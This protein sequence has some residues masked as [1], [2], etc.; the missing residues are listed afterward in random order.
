MKA[1]IQ[2]LSKSL[3]SGNLVEPCGD[4]SVVCL[5]GRNALKTMINDGHRF[6]GFRRPNYPHFRV[7]QGDFRHSICVFSTVPNEQRL[8]SI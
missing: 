5:D 4:R 6:N 8:I 3:I 2:Y 1:Y 7:M